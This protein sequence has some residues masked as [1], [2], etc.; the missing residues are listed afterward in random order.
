VAGEEPLTPIA[1]I[2]KA[3]EHQDI[4]VQAVVSRV[5]EGQNRRPYFVT[6]AEGDA[7][8]PLVYWSDMQPQL[9]PKVKVGNLIRAK[10][11]VSVYRDQLELHVSDP[12]ALEVVS[13]T[14]GTTVNA[15]SA[16]TVTPTATVTST[17]A[18]I[19]GAP[20]TET[21]I[22]KIKADWADRAV[23]ISGTVSDFR[24]TGKVWQLKVQDRTGEIAVVLGEKVLAGLAVTELKPGWVVAVTG[25][26][27]VYE[28]KPAVVPEVAGAVKVTP[29]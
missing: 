15:S 9:G 25:P 3:L 24:A 14:T 22:G 1:R 17:A 12:D 5:A 18:A 16:A 20:P 19:P 4:T 27:K 26:V 10:V 2:N 6:L 23:I 7:T 21:V 8:I 11:T 28:G 29:Q 13:G